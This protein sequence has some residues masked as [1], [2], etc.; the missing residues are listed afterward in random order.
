[1]ALEDLQ[2]RL[3]ASLAG[4]PEGPEGLDSRALDRA[5]SSLEAKRRRAA[6]HLL[7]LLRN[8]LGADWSRRFHEHC[9]S[10]NPAGGLHHV[11][12]AWAFAEAVLQE[13]DPGL[14][15]AAHDDLLTLRLR[16]IRDPAAGAARIRERR[17]LFVALSRKNPRFLVLRLPGASGRV[18]RVNL[19]FFH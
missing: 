14:A 7:P 18:F 5:R 1:M 6:G 10:Y 19:G 16:W 11:D 3:A 17:M 9:R 2:R 8:A 12:D 4:R 15:P 13:S